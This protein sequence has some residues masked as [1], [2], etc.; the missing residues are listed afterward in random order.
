[1]RASTRGFFPARTR[2][3]QTDFLRI[4][5]FS[6]ALAL[7][8]SQNFAVATAC[9]VALISL[10][11]IVLLR[12]CAQVK[13]G[14]ISFTILSNGALLADVPGYH[15]AEYVYP[16]GYKVPSPFC[17]S[18]CCAELSQANMSLQRLLAPR[19]LPGARSAGVGM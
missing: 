9:P 13:D 16:V 18:P 19:C 7:Q 8:R 14:P 2:C 1:M 4:V 6:A 11:R 3:Y 5:L 17:T 12:V 15:T 10:P